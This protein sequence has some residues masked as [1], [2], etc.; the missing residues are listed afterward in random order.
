M[1]GEKSWRLA[2]P[3][4]EGRSSMRTAAGI[5]REYGLPEPPSGVDRYYSTCPKCSA[6]RSTANQK[7]KCL[8]IDIDDK[9]VRFHCCHCN[10]GGG[11]YYN[12]KAN[13]KDHARARANVVGE[14]QYHDESGNVRFVVERRESSDGKKTFKQ[15]CPDPEC[16]GKWKWSVKGIR[17]IPYRLPQLIEAIAA[18]HP[19]FIVEGERKVDL[20]LSWNVAATCNAMGAGKWKQE[21]AEFL[22]GADVV[23]MPD[24]DDAGWNHINI[25]GASL[26]G[27]AKRIRV[28]VLPHAKAK[29]DIIDWAKA[30]GTREQLDAL[31]NQAQ[32]WKPPSADEEASADEKAK[33]KAREDELLAALAEARGL[34]YARQR[35]SAAQELGVT[36]KAIDDEVR[37]RREDAQVAP[38]YG[39][40]IVEPWPEPID[41]D[42]LLRDIIRRIKRHVIISDDGALVAALWVMLSWVHDDVAT[43]SPI[44]N[45]NSAEPESGKST[46]MGLIAFL[47]PRCIASVE[48]A[49]RQSIVRSNAGRH[50]S[51]STNST[52]S[53]STTTRP[54]CA[55]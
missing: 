25:V 34:D 4:A 44:L 21:H 24:N 15:R 6:Q 52:A 38:L 41:G 31:L 1:A 18:D 55:R 3:Y 5:L 8:G 51:A 32:D 48:A 11:A 7:T 29:D 54:R 49:K 53:L 30:G 43:H 37:A 16:P 19:I 50:L 45:I 27:T 17:Q 9:G 12:G 23:L 13:G 36:A 20:L 35:K 22:R 46:M 33:A 42:S 26:V 10:W 39:H 2:D 28:L 40:W 47:M 14:F